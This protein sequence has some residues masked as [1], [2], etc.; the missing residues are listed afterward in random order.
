MNMGGMRRAGGNEEVR[1]CGKRS[2]RRTT[3]DEIVSEI[4][5]FK[6]K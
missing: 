6:E 3:Q 5:V 2:G 1:K 4:S